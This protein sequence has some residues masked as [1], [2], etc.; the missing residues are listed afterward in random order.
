LEN[1]GFAGEF[2]GIG[3]WLAQDDQ[4]I[5]IDSTLPDSSAERAGLQPGDRLLAVE[6]DEVDAGLLAGAALLVRGPLPSTVRLLVERNG[7]EQSLDMPRMVV[8]LPSVEWQLLAPWLGYVRIEQFTGRTSSEFAV[9]LSE[10][11]GIG[12]KALLLDLRDNGGGVPSTA[13]E[14]LS[15]LVAG[16]IAYRE[17]RADGEETRVVIPFAATSPDPAPVAILVNG[18]TASAAE[19]V[20]AAIQDYERGPLVG[21]TTFGKGSVQGLF[22]LRDGSSIRITTSRWLTPLGRHI[23]GVG[24]QPD[25]VSNSD[26]DT[27]SLAVDHLAKRLGVQPES[28]ELPRP[29][30]K[31][32][33]VLV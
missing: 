5:F 31:D 13:V 6:D 29:D 15:Q 18:G 20:A 17:L 25:L 21:S 14:V 1:D 9:A 12:A 26:A 11:R 22:T 7:T 24:L 10:L 27:L 19:I 3:A 33:K 2:G 28:P 30:D 8:E 16:S 4:G 32:G 23:E